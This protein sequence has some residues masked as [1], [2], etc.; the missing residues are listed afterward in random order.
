MSELHILLGINRHKHSRNRE[1]KTGTLRCWRG[2]DD[3]NGSSSLSQI[4]GI[5]LQKISL[6]CEQLYGASSKDKTEE[7]K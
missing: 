7:S 3:S 5:K 1:S 6:R 2:D 4:L